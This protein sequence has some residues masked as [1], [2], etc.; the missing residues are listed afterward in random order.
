M[1]FPKVYLLKPISNP[2]MTMQRAIMCY[3]QGA[4]GQAGL[5]ALASRRNAAGAIVPLQTSFICEFEIGSKFG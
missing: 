3:E 5:E 1:C 4:P 2:K